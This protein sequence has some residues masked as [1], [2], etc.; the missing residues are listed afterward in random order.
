MTASEHGVHVLECSGTNHVQLAVSPFLGGCTVIADSAGDFVRSQPILEGDGGKQ[1]CRA[2]KVV[3]AAVAGTA[4]DEGLAI[5]RGVLR[6]T[7]Q[8]IVLAHDADH[9]FALAPG[10]GEGRWHAR[11]TIGQGESRRAQFGL[12]QAGALVFLEADFGELPDFARNI[13]VVRRVPVHGLEDGTL[14]VGQHR[15]SGEK[16]EQKNP[17]R[18]RIANLTK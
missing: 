12:E 17:H 16:E 11:D 1:R 4:V 6:E 2:Q 15:S 10:S 14:I 3:A 9:R 8:C 13:T 18:M 7:G 5:R